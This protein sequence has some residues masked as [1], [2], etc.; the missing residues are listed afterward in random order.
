MHFLLIFRGFLLNVHLHRRDNYGLFHELRLLRRFLYNISIGGGGRRREIAGGRGR[1]ARRL[2]EIAGGRGRSGRRSIEMRV[3][4]TH[5][6]CYPCACRATRPLRGEKLRLRPRVRVRVRGS[7]RGRGSVYGR[8]GH[9]PR[10]GRGRGGRAMPG[11]G[12]GLG[13]GLELW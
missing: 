12:L 4:V 8:G 7:V 3:A 10:G 5:R 1:S 9:W 13:L 2:I 11:V 6:R